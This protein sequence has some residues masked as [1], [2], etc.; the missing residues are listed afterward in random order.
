MGRPP[1]P[2]LSHRGAAGVTDADG[3]RG[4]ACSCCARAGRHSSEE[5]KA[6][7]AYLEDGP[8]LVLMAMNGWMEGSP[9]WW[10][11]LQAQPE[12]TVVLRDGPREVHARRA[13]DE[14]H[15]R[16]WARWKELDGENLDTWASRRSDTAIVIL[17]PRADAPSR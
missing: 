17:E 9:G 15:A 8:N 4:G 11:N 2:L 16:W 3:R 10:L 7:L 1:R 14:E 13:T 6:I 12:A 5:R